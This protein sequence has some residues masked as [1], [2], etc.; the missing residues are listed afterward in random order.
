[1]T[2]VQKGN[3]ENGY[4]EILNMDALKNKDFVTKGAYTLLMKMKNN[5][6]E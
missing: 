5:A 4:V 3:T 1:M 2:A 6:E